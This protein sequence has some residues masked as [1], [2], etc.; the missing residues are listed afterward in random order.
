[1]G[2]GL[3]VY[4]IIPEEEFEEAQKLLESQNLEE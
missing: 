2:R 4:I 3:P 1:M